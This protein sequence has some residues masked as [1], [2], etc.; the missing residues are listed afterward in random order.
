MRG[1]RER[2]R[3]TGVMALVAVAA[4]SGACGGSESGL[5]NGDGVVVHDLARVLAVSE[6]FGFLQSV[7]ERPDGRL[8]V[9]DPLGSLFVAL[10]PRTGEMEP[11]GR[12]GGGPG[13]WRQPD[14]VHRLPGDSTLLV[15]LGNA[16]LS[17]LDPDG[18]F[19][20]S[21]PMALLPAAS[22]ESVGERSGPRGPGQGQGG[23]GGA[24]AGPGRGVFGAGGPPEVIQPR[25]TDARGRIYY[26]TRGGPLGPGGSPGAAPDSMQVKRWDRG[27]APPVRLAG[28]RPAAL[29]STTSGGAGNVAVRARPIPLAPQDDWAVT[30]DGSIAL[31]RA[32]PYHVEW[33]GADG[34]VVVGPAVSFTPVPVG[35]P[36][37]QRWVE[38]LGESGL[39]MMMTVDG[40]SVN[41]QF[42][43]GGG[44]GPQGAQGGV[45][46]YE[47]P[48]TL[49]AFRPGGARVDPEGRL[50]VE[51]YGSAGSPTLYD[52][53]DRGGELTGR[54]RLPAE[55]RVIGFGR[56]V[57][58]VVH[59]DDLGLNWLEI[60]ETPR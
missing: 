46:D 20:G 17:V 18:Q 12:E 52:L 8:L 21:Y 27:D 45:D 6:S 22:A 3:I 9:A 15:D 29:A 60:F 57:V 47:W 50:W 53:F 16:R 28:L 7:V 58:H 37:K 59:V 19:T 39:S 48:A 49:P 56:N 33:L 31:V 30:S 41:M 14:A 44:M 24:M 35:E 4:V 1:P 34:S 40:G 2:D 11:V 43:R 26:Q 42:R 55:R 54:V 51:R 23:G 38:S 25:A 5:R 10:D 32:E 13:E 36:E